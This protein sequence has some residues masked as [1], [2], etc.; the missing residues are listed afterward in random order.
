MEFPS[1]HLQTPRFATPSL[2]TGPPSYRTEAGYNLLL[3]P[4]G[5]RWWRLDYRY[6]GKRKTLSMGVYPDVSLK[7][8]RTRRDEARKLLAADVDP[9]ENRK[10]LKALKATKIEQGSNSFEV[11]AREWFAKYSPGYAKG[12][13]DKII[14]R[15]ERDM[16][17]WI[18][19][20]PI[21]EITAPELLQSLRR[22]EARGFLCVA[23]CK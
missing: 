18:G 8:A 23:Y 2:Q 4:S 10:A 22:I 21:A 5:A 16:F 12:H 3:K 11:V 20:R 17:P 7:G 1:W 14:R 19:S 15:L 9:G 6:S 13:A